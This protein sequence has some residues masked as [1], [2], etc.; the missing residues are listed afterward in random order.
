MGGC[1]WQE[2]LEFAV[3]ID[4]NIAS[5]RHLYRYTIDVDVKASVNKEVL[6]DPSKKLAARKAIKAKFEERYTSGK[7]KWFFSKL[8]CADMV[9]SHGSTL[10]K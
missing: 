2:V 8:R 6:A 7:N 3:F 10:W 9:D 1:G 5:G 4:I